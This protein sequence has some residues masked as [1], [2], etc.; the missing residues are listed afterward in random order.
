MILVLS[1]KRAQLHNTGASARRVGLINLLAVALDLRLWRDN[2]R[3]I[4]SAGNVTVSS[5]FPLFL[6]CYFLL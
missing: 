6:F 5:F 3:G 4:A 2:K 1:S